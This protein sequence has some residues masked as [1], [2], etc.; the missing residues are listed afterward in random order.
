VDGQPENGN[1]VRYRVG[2]LEKARE[3]DREATR[4]LADFG[5]RNNEQ[6]RVH[7]QRFIDLEKEVDGMRSAVADVPV[8]R[9]R[10]DTAI[11][12]MK[13]IRTA[14]YSAAASLLVVAGAVVFTQ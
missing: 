7:D 12:S 14:L 8:L 2:E 4:L 6:I 1:T 3:Q 5:R 10:L 9:E 11:D 13:S